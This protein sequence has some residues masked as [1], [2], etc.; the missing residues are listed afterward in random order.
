VESR[1]R[2]PESHEAKAMTMFC[3]FIVENHISSEINYPMALSKDDEGE[4][5]KE[6][7]KWVSNSS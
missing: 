6:M 4:R 2:V 7:P 5:Y 1:A 3:S